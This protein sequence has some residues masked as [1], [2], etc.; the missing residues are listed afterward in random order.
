MATP[1]WRF[2]YWRNPN[3]DADGHTYS[4][5]YSYGNTNTNSNRNTWS[6]SAQRSGEKD[7]GNKYITS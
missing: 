5:C 1:N 7:W 3:S 6:D 4:N 2:Y